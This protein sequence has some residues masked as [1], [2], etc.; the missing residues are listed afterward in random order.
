MK[1]YKLIEKQY[2]WL[3]GVCYGRKNEYEKVPF[4]IQKTAYY[5]LRECGYN[6]EYDDE[7]RRE[8]LWLR[9]QY[10]KWRNS[11][12]ELDDLPF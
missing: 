12:D 6:R 8:L 3:L 10:I 11:R 1:R 9:D 2:K 4:E 5:I 7:F